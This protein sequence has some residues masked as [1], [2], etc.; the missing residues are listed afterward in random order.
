MI[1]NKLRDS[2]PLATRLNIELDS[3]TAGA[4]RIT[5]LRGYSVIV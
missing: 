4:T 3:A 2:G 5:L 1:A